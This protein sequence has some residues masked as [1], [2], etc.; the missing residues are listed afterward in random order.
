MSRTK[1]NVM[2]K[3]NNYGLLD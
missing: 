2:K 1:K 3:N